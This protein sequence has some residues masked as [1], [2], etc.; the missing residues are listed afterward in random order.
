M[1]WRH[2]RI[3]AWWAE[4]VC[5]IFVLPK[6]DYRL[7]DPTISL[8]RELQNEGNCKYLPTIWSRRRS[9]YPRHVPIAERRRAGARAG[10]LRHHVRPSACGR[11]RSGAKT[12]P[13]RGSAGTVPDTQIRDP[14]MPHSEP[15]SAA[16]SCVPSQCVVPARFSAPAG[17]RTWS[18]VP[19]TDGSPARTGT[20]DA[21]KATGTP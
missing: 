10:T 5:P 16:A 1:T 9:R 4:G 6:N 18:H 15:P 2:C 21:L 13:G 7:A 3:R 17:E 11:P 12:S 19:V 14:W 20:G 8:E